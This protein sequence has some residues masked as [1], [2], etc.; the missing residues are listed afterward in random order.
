MNVDEDDEEEEDEDEDNNSNI[1]SIDISEP[2]L[3]ASQPY[4]EER[5]I[6]SRPLR[7]SKAFHDKELLDQ[8]VNISGLV[9]TK[10]N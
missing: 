5:Q 4:S 9:N 7:K 6:L 2:S 10:S 3:V 8:Q 1:I